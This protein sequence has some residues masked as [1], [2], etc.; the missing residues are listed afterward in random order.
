VNLAAAEVLPV[1]QDLLH[2]ITGPKASRDF[3]AWRAKLV[4]PLACVVPPC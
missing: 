1:L 4:E 2:A 3:V